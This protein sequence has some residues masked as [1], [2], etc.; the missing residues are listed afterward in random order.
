[1]L[2]FKNILWMIIILFAFIL[3]AKIENDM[4]LIKKG[5]YTPLFTHNKSLSKDIFI[6]HDFYINKYPITNEEFYKFITNNERWN[7]NNIKMIFADRDYLSHWKEC[8]KFDNIKYY[9]VVNISWYVAQAYCNYINGRLP[10]VDEWEY[11]ASL[12]QVDKNGKKDLSYLDKILTWYTR[13]QNIKL[14]L[15]EE[16]NSNYL[17]IYSMNSIL[18]EWVSDFN[19]VI[20][21]NTDAEGGGLEEALFCGA[22]ATSAVDPAD[23]IAFMRFA[24]R[25]SLEAN[26]TMSNLSFRCVKDV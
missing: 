2:I 9:P 4:V 23:Y 24:F 11:V 22:S 19:S 16:M 25:N 21:L 7:Y 1:M 6:D 14:L 15:R 10:T 5:K 20:L 8:D 12:R 13:T 18:W 26:Y 17:G 3:E